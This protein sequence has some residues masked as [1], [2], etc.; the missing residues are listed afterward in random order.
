M[1]VDVAIADALVLT[2]D[3]RN[4]LYERGTVLVDDGRIT[5]VRTSGDGDGEI[6]ATHTIDGD[7]SLVMPGLVNAHTHLELTQ[8]IV[9]FYPIESVSRVASSGPSAGRRSIARLRYLP[10]SVGNPPLS[11]GGGRRSGDVGR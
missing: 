4:R 2:V 7:G 6:E 10:T 8:L 9:P 3:D 5:E 11:G 1:P